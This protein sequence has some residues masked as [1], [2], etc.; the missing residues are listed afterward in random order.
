M[1]CDCAIMVTTTITAVDKNC[2]EKCK[3]SNT[4]MDVWLFKAIGLY[5]LLRPCNSI[6]VGHGYRTIALVALW[7]TFGLQVMQV[8]RLY[9]TLGDFQLFLFT[10]VIS[11]NGLVSLYKGYVIVTNADK[12]WTVL[13]VARYRFT[14]CGYRDKT[15]LRRCGK[16]MSIWLR[17]YVVFNYILLTI[18]ALFP[19]VMNDHVPFVKLDG[20]V[21]HY[22]Q[23]MIN[24]WFPVSEN[25]HNWTPVWTL[26]NVV[27]TVFAS[28]SVISWIMFDCYVL[29]TCM[30]LSVQFR[31]M[32]TAY[33]MLGQESTKCAGELKADSTMHYS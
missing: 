7:L 24:M 28:I 14:S 16:T 32:S 22:R 18:W 17:T 12:L 19:W 5:H 25:V 3:S 10:T 9:L 23:T 20:S 4:A 21:G 30:V 8:V 27:E 15:K 29:F 31:T 11:I 33:E 6:S 26:I 2:H 1:W 13:D